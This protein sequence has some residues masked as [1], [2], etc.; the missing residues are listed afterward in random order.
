MMDM[1]TS[2]SWFAVT[3]LIHIFIGINSEELNYNKVHL[4]DYKILDNSTQLTNFLFRGNSPIVNDTEFG[5]DTLISY[6]QQRIADANLT[7][8]KNDQFYFI[9]ICLDNIFDGT[10]YYIEQKFWA[11]KGNETNFGILQHWP[12]ATSASIVSPKMVPDPSIW[13]ETCNS[14]DLW[15]IDQIPSRISFANS[16]LTTKRSDNIPLIIYVHCVGGCDRTGEFVATYRLKYGGTDMNIIH[17]N[18]TQIYDLDVSECGR[19]PDYWSTTSI[20]W[21]CVCYRIDTDDY[22]IGDCTEIADC[23]Y[24]GS[25]QPT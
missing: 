3:L 10:D 11:R 21:Y 2:T 16:L 5:Y 13:K 22:N 19:A 20:E 9:D 6:F 23:K 14:G 8:P 7:F 1:H 18:I 24:G 25:C 12:I 4:V 17:K 15:L